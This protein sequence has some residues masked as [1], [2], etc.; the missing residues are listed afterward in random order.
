[1][2]I[3]TNDGIDKFGTQDAT[4]TTSASVADAAF[5]I[6][7]DLSTWTNDDDA[8]RA[9]IIL[10]ATYSVAPTASSGVT[11]YARLLNI[12]STNDADVPDANFLQT[13]LGRFPLNDVT[14]A[15]YIAID[16][17][18]PNTK[19]SQEY[20]FYIKNDG[21]QTISAGWDIH[22]TPKTHGPHA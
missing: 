6:A 22:V 21:G 1:M 18:L 13:Y 20:E 11:L 19:T 7:S 9:T 12:V 5:S 16:A 3:G 2:A 10:E 8:W 15:Q 14:T 4:G 17:Y